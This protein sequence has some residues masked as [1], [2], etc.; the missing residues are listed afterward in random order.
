MSY[1]DLNLKDVENY[2]NI[3]LSQGREKGV[4]FC[5]QMS[6]LCKK[7]HDKEVRHL[8]ARIEDLKRELLK[9]KDSEAWESL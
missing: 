5:I 8:R 6:L 3:I 2:T 4:G 7:A 1:Q 9:Y